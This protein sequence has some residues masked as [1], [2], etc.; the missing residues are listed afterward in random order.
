MGQLYG[1]FNDMTHE[2]TDGVLHLVVTNPVLDTTEPGTQGNQIAQLNIHD[3][4]Q[5]I[6]G[7]KAGLRSGRDGDNHRAE[8][9][10][11]VSAEGGAF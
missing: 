5:A 2:W 4:L 11:P 8:I 10:Y 1:E 9:Y 6:Y 7:P 3:R